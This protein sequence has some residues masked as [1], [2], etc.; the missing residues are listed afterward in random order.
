MTATCLV[1][2][3]SRIAIVRSYFHYGKQNNSFV[4][5]AKYLTEIEQNVRYRF[6][7]ANRSVSNTN[8]HN[9]FFYTMKKSPRGGKFKP[10]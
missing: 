2:E 8:R 3:V 9:N 5:Y 1:L 7:R 4:L 10:I 6:I